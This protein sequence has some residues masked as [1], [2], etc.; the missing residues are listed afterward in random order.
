MKKKILILLVTQALTFLSFSQEAEKKTDLSGYV[1]TLTSSIFESVSDPFLIDHLVHNRLNFKAY[2]TPE[3][4]FAV[5]ARNR[6][7][8]G[9]MVRLNSNYSTMI[10]TDQGIMDLS[11]NIADKNSFFLNTTIDRMWLDFNSGKFQARV[12]RQ[13]INWGQALIWNPNDIFNAYSYF[14]FDYV[15]RP[16]SDAVRLQYYPDY[17]SA[18]EFAVKANSE[19]EITAAALFRFNKWSY[20]IQFLSGI[21]ENDELVAGFGWSGAIGSVSVRGEATW[22]QPFENFSDTTGTGM[23]TAGID[24]IFGNNSMLQAQIL[25]SNNPYD[26]GVV[27]GLYSSG[28]MSVK[29]LAFSKFSAFAS[30]S[31]PITPLFNSGISAMW[32]PG[33]DG[34]FTGVSADYSAA[35]NIDVTLLWQHFNGVFGSGERTKINLGFLRIKFSF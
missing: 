33:R 23:L 3:L 31:Y 19:D 16:G 30:Y 20:D 12:G 11:W 26:F 13:R 6:F 35:E 4:T 17:S 24:K 10:A 21:F 29:D 22:F 14:D 18:I 1:S 28:S 34:F 9:D 15:E 27:T 2:M 25:L 7:L 32:F 8:M 5:E